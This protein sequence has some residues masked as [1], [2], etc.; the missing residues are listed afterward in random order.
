VTVDIETSPPPPRFSM[1]AYWIASIQRMVTGAVLE[2]V[3]EDAIYQAVVDAIEEA[4]R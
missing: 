3:A 2:G 4:R 1:A